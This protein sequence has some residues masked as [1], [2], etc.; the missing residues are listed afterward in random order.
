MKVSKVSKVAKQHNHMIGS[1][2]MLTIKRG[3]LQNPSMP[4]HV[5]NFNAR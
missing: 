4:A 2:T 3:M 1:M 5:M